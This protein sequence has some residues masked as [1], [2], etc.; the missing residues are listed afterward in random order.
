[1]GGHFDLIRTVLHDP[2]GFLSRV[3]SG[4]RRN[5]GLFLAG[6]VAYFTLLSIVPLGIL[7]L[8]VLSHLMDQARVIQMSSTY[9]ELIVPGQSR[10]L[11]HE[12]ELFLGHRRVI[13]VVGLA[14]LLMFSSMAFTA[15]E[16][17]MSVIFHHRV[18]IK[19]RH[20]LVSAIIPYI[21]ILFLGLGLV[22]VSLISGALETLGQGSVELLGSTWS[23]A[24]VTGVVIYLI[25][26]AGE[27]L[28]LTSLYLVMPVGRLALSHALVGGVAAGVLWE[29]T[30][31]VL[32]WYFS[33]L[34][35][36][37]VIYGSMATAIVIL[38]T[39]EVASVIVL[40][41]AQIIAEYERGPP[42]QDAHEALRT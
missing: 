26:V 34:S 5:Q 28:L 31:H 4:F 42:E 10:Y 27:I 24:G 8:V 16:N 37:N 39:F 20:F 15:L 11:I 3:M 2:L 12:V 25:G 23:L 14:M 6:A 41:G 33:T 1:M 38:I 22:V 19:R 18:A 9:L 40:L 30:R 32:V 13:G 36:V 21:Y 35:V 29:V 17:A 7:M